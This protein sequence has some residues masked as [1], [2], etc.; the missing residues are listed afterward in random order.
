MNQP[1]ENTPSTPQTQNQPE[2][3]IIKNP[4]LVKTIIIAVICVVIL[5]L[6]SIIVLNQIKQ[7]NTQTQV[8]NGKTLV[9]LVFNLRN[10]IDTFYQKNQSYKSWQADSQIL[11][12]ATSLGSTINVV[13]PDFQ[14]YMF[15]AFIP[16]DQ[17]YFCVDNTQFAGEINKISVNQT[18]CQ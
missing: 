10:E 6:T 17:K 5:V 18:K 13:R 2:K 14:H 15:Y 16:A 3:P 9:Q 7:K 11:A 12:Q 4:R 1:V 8:K